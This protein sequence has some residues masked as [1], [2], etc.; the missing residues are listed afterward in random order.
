MEICELS[1]VRL[2]R[3]ESQPRLVSSELGPTKAL[4]MSILSHVP[5]SHATH[6]IYPWHRLALH[7]AEGFITASTTLRKELRSSLGRDK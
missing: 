1:T 3:E 2:Q 4:H 5:P 6:D 7:N